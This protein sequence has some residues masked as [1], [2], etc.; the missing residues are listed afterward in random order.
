MIRNDVK[1]RQICTLFIAF[2]PLIKIVGAPAVFSGFCGEKLWLPALILFLIDFLLIFLYMFYAKKFEG[3]PYFEILSDDYGKTFAKTVFFIYGIFFLI[4]AFIPICEYK[5]LVEAGFYEV[6]PRSEI[7]FPMF[8][9]VLYISIKGLKVFARCSEIAAPVTVVGLAILFYLTVGSGEFENLLP[10]FYGSGAKEINCV[11]RNPFWFNDAAYLLMFCGHFKNEKRMTL[12]VCISYAVSALTTVFFFMCF[13]AV[14][15][16]VSPIQK[17]ALSAVSIFSVTLVNVGR[18]DYFALFLLVL[19]GV[20]AL[21]L[22]VF[23]A[24]KCFSRSFGVRKTTVPAIIV[25]GIL[26]AAVGLYSSKLDF[27][28]ELFQKYLSPFFWICG[29]GLPLLGL[30]GCILK[31]KNQPLKQKIDSDA[32]EQTENADEQIKNKNAGNAFADN[33]NEN[34]NENGDKKGNENGGAK[35]GKERQKRATAGVKSK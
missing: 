1:V 31:R 15:Y 2:L 16:T 24:T 26:L 30:K 9:L 27:I 11:Y 34:G 23:A 19:S 18:F 7:F 14:F 35:F 4:K 13:Y 3:K 25:N 32:G 28:I 22:P 17:T 29:Y 6:M 12:R 21:S 8:V 33:G 20:F 5:Y 10:L